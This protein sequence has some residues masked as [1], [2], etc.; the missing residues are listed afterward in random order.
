MIASLSV[1]LVNYNG[2]MILIKSNW[3]I[4]DLE[5]GFPYYLQE[6][7]RGVLGCVLRRTS[8]SQLSRTNSLKET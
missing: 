3:I 2:D 8:P 1:L 5:C 6:D 7:P 4:I